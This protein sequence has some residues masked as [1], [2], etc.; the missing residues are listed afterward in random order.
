MIQLLCLVAAAVVEQAEP[1]QRRAGAPPARPSPVAG[2]TS[3]TKFAS[4]WMTATFRTHPGDPRRG[5]YVRRAIRGRVGAARVAHR[6]A[7]HRACGQRGI[8]MRAYAAGDA[9]GITHS[10]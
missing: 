7:P 5:A 6:D 8:V 2:S 4:S 3:A 1:P 10:Y 9:V